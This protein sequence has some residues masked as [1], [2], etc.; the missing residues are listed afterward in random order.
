MPRLILPPAKYDKPYTGTLY[1]LR[2][3]D[4]YILQQICGNDRLLI[5]CAVHSETSCLIVLG[6][7]AQNDERVMRHERAHC[8]GWPAHHPG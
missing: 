8:E 5:A 3:D 1:V 6:P 7:V 2:M 4:N